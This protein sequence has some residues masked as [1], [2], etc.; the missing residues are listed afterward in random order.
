MMDLGRRPWAQGPPEAR[1]GG[2]LWLFFSLKVVKFSA[3]A[4][5]KA[6]RTYAGTGRC[7]AREGMDR[8]GRGRGRR[9]V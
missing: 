4:V 8:W 2:V 3:L 9:F 6:Q 5:A 1:G 7:Q